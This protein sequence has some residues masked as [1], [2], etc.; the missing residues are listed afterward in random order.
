MHILHMGWAISNIAD[1]RTYEC[2]STYLLSLTIV[3][4]IGQSL[5][6]KT[7]KN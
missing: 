1:F 3:D 5:A 7:H 2:S 6:V 4:S